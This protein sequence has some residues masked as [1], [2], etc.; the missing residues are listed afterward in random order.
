M[1]NNVQEI[2]ITKEGHN[3]FKK[4]LAILQKKRQDEIQDKLHS[5]EFK[6][7]ND[8]DIDFIDSNEEIEEN[9]YNFLINLVLNAIIID[10]SDK[11]NDKILFGSLIKLVEGE[12]TYFTYKIVGYPEVNVEK[13]YISYLSPIGKS[14]INKSVGDIILT[15]DGREL[16][17]LEITN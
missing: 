15:K 16:E 1:S 12:D 11:P 10:N 6:S 8:E 13:G 2:L 5:Y 9:K 17:I 7:P 4:E 3:H 14:L